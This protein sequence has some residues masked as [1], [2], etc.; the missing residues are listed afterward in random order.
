MDNPISATDKADNTWN[1]SPLYKGTGSS[2]YFFTCTGTEMC[3]YFWSLFISV[4][5]NCIFILSW[6]II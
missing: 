6:W 3:N 5:F 2:N 4:I 1:I